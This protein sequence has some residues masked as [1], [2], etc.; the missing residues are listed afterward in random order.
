MPL[1]WALGSH[2]HPHAEDTEFQ[3]SFAE[4]LQVGHASF[5]KQEASLTFH[6]ISLQQMK[7]ILVLFC[8]LVTS[9]VQLLQ[10]ALD[11]ESPSL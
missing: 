2:P 1:L 8:A 5:E 11:R 6:H 7:H 3:E 4:G 9:L 10:S